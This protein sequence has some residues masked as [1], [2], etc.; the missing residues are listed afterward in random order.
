M[1]RPRACLITLR[2]LLEVLGSAPQPTR[3]I[4]Q[5]WHAVRSNDRIIAR[6]R[7]CQSLPYLRILAPTA[8]L[9]R[10]RSRQLSASLAMTSR[11]CWINPSPINIAVPSVSASGDC[12]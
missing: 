10:K 2:N 8:P 11:A 9:R 3:V 6:Q 1:N 4:A 7:W 12:R 5:A